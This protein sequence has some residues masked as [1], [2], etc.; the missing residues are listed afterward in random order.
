MGRILTVAANN[1]NRIQGVF[2]SV[3]DLARRVNLRGLRLCGPLGALL[4]PVIAHAEF[5]GR[6]AASTQF[7]SNSNVFDQ[8]GGLQGRPSASDTYYAYGAELAGVYVFGRQNL[9][10][11]A[12]TKQ[13][14]Y[15]R[16]SQLDHND[17]R[18]V[19]QF[20]WKLF[21]NL[22]GLIGQTR[23][24]TM[25]PFLDLGGDQTGLS[26][27][28][29][30]REV[31]QFNWKVNSDWRFEGVGNRSSTEQP[32]DGAPNLQ[33]V[34]TAG[35]GT[36]KY[37]GIGRF[38]SG[39][40]A[41]YLSGGFS[42]ATNI[43]N[44]TR[45]TSPSYHQSHASWVASFES[46]RSNFEGEIGYTTR[47][48]SAGSDS[49]SGLTGLLDFTYNLTPK[50]AWRVK[51]DRAVSSFVLNSGSEIDT[52]GS[53]GINWRPS[54]KLFTSLDYTYSYRDYPGQGDTP[55]TNRIDHQQFAIFSLTYQPKRWLLIHP[56]ANWQ[57]RHSNFAGRDSDSTVFGISLTL[58]TS[59]T[60]NQNTV[61]LEIH[62]H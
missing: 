11:R 1:S 59:D 3:N 46:K 48:S 12:E 33:L 22:D 27:S 60:A 56:Y 43:Q 44:N 40:S 10:A 14:E 58:Q 62:W 16:F 9:Y 8:S 13:F 26:I 23:S 45:T 5:V 35:T 31:A 15:Q 25:V 2:A 55:G 52:D 42:G 4:L 28:V 24:H 18:I 36:L 57:V 30:Q 7:E 6:A 20:V 51:V 17:Y 29:Q 41:G 32:I 39:V 37:L 50:T 21:N 61:P 54:Y 47:G 34:E 53:V 38:T 19:T 49:T